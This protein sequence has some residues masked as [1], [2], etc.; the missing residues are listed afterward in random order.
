[1]IAIIKKTF[2]G[3][4]QRFFLLSK[5]FFN[6]RTVKILFLIKGILENI[7]NLYRLYAVLKEPIILEPKDK[8]FDRI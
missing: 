2:A 3:F 5:P 4:T 6:R 7:K 1:L 8:F